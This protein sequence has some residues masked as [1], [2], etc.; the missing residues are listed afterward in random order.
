MCEDWGVV[1]RGQ[2]KKPIIFADGPLQTRNVLVKKK[3]HKH[4]SVF[5]LAA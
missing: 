1:V 5:A 4:C 3:E 2:R